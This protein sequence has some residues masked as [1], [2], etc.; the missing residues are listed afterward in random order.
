MMK[1]LNSTVGAK[2]MVWQ[3][4]SLEVFGVAESF[5]IGLSIGKYADVNRIEASSTFVT[6][7]AVC[8]TNLATADI[9]RGVT[10]SLQL[11]NGNALISL[12]NTDETTVG[13]FAQGSLGNKYK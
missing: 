2:I 8:T 4:Q 1:M 7:L 5:F 3:V 12:A 6:P 9:R 13:G 10:T 11:T